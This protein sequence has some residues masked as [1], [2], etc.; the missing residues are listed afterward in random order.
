MQLY[1]DRAMTLLSSSCYLLYSYSNPIIPLMIERNAAE[2]VTRGRSVFEQQLKHVKMNQSNA[3]RKRHRYSYS[4]SLMPVP[5]QMNAAWSLFVCVSIQQ[6]NHVI[7]FNILW[8]IKT[9]NILG[10]ILHLVDAA[11]DNLI[12]I[13]HE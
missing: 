3:V 12:N 7:T 8:D 11:V 4:N 13:F 2:K 5:Y 9:G 10:S 6:T 1:T